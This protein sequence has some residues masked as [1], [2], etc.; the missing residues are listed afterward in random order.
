MTFF[1][2]GLGIGCVFGGCIGF[3][4]AA[5]LAAGKSED[6]LRGFDRDNEHAPFRH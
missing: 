4:I 6:I 2:I 3:L 1:L 5:V